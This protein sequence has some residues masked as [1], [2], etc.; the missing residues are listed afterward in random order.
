M[1][2]SDKGIISLV[3]HEGIV[4]G[5][6]L[7]SVGVWTWGVGHTAAA[8][9]LKPANMPR[10]FPNDL[11]ATLD[12]VFAVFAKDIQKYEAG[13]LKALKVPVSQHEF[14]ALVSFH[15]NTGAIAKAAL[16]NFLN[17]GNRKAAADAF[18]NYRR[19]A[20]IIERR[21]AEQELFLTGKYP[22]GRIN[23]WGVTASG[24]VV[25]KPQMTLSQ[26]EV[27]ERFRGAGPAAPI[28]VKPPRRPV[29]R[30]GSSGPSIADMQRLLNMAGAKLTVDGRFGPAS[31]EAVRKY[32]RSQGL[33]GDG[34]VGPKTWSKLD[35]VN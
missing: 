21:E 27:L 4:P 13:V 10:G 31:D 19:P 1:R 3:S 12:Q 6:Y 15:Y 22:T 14:D 11:D 5:P 16:T 29:I 24:R 7:D 28:V 23:V 32:Q 35:G 30:I 18:M 17:A 9:G 33:Y 20:E 2:T 8:G 25:W 26:D 34:V